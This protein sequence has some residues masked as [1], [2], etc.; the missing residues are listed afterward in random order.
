MQNPDMILVPY[1]IGHHQKNGD[2]GRYTSQLKPDRL[3]G[4][5]TFAISDDKKGKNICRNAQYKRK[6]CST[7]PSHGW[8][9]RLLIYF[10]LP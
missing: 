3:I 10:P 2:N 7:I 4:H 1:N 9:T 6:R 5:F 8:D